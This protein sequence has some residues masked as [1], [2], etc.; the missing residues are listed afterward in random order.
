MKI[1]MDRT[2][3]FLCFFTLFI[4][5]NQAFEMLLLYFILQLRRTGMDGK[6]RRSWNG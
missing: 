3:H 5:K 4:V 1:E 6:R 2:F